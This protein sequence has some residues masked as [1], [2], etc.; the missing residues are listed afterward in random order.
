M[1]ARRIVAEGFSLYRGRRKRQACGVFLQAPA[2]VKLLS[3]ELRSTGY[4]DLAD[5]Q[6]TPP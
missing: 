1:G 2:E 4:S 5:Y 3:A 6:P